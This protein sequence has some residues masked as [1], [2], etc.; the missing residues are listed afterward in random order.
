MPYEIVVDEKTGERR[1]VVTGAVYKPKAGEQPKGAG[2]TLPSPMDLYEATR[3]L[4]PQGMLESGVKMGAQVVGRGVQELQRTGDLGKAVT[5]AG[6]E[7]GR[8]MQA[9]SMIGARVGY[10]AARDLAQSVLG[11]LPAA[12]SRKPGQ[13]DSPILGVMPPLPRIKSTGAGEDLVTGFMQGAMAWILAARGG[14]L[15]AKG[16]TAIPGVGTAA[17]ATRTAAAFAQ[18]GGAVPRLAIGATKAVVKGAPTGLVVD[19]LA[20]TPGEQTMVGQILD[21]AEKQSGTPL[22]GPLVDLFRTKPGDT[23][24]D[25]RWKEGVGGLAVVGPGAE[26]VIRTTGLAA[27]AL[28]NLAKVRQAAAAS[29]AP[30]PAP[31]PTPTPAAPTPAPTAAA[32]AAVPTPA[33]AT[34]PAAPTAVV[35]A[36]VAVAAPQRQAKIDVAQQ[37][38]DAAKAK[39]DAIGPEPS[40]P[41]S[42]KKRFGA[43]G[44]AGA[45]PADVAQWKAETSTY[46]SWRRQYLK[47]KREEVAAANQLVAAK[48]ESQAPV[49]PT[50]AQTEVEEAAAQAV[51][52]VA[53]M[54]AA[55]QAAVERGQQV[56]QQVTTPPVAP[57][58]PAVGTPA[59]PSAGPPVATAPAGGLD[60]ADIA[61]LRD[62][63]GL[64][65]EEAALFREAADLLESMD[66]TTTKGIQDAR[67][68]LDRV[69][70]SER[71]FLLEGAAPT[72]R[73]AAIERLNKALEMP[74]VE[75][76][77]AP[78]AAPAPQPQAAAQA[79]AAPIDIPPGASRKITERTNENRIQVAAE[80]LASWLA[81]ING[82]KPLP[83]DRALDLVRAKGAILD[84]DAIPNLDMEA[85]RSD[86]T[87]WKAVSNTA[88]IDPVANAYKQ[89]Y[90]ARTSGAKSFDGLESPTLAPEQPPAPAAVPAAQ[91]QAA[92]TATAVAPGQAGLPDTRGQGQFFH[93]AAQEFK[94]TEGG[95]YAGDG[96]NIYGNGFYATED[97][98]TAAAYQKKNIK[99][100]PVVTMYAASNELSGAGATPAEINWLEGRGR[101]NAPA[102]TQE[103]MQEIA[104]NLRKE[105]SQ[106]P[107]N[108]ITQ[109]QLK[110]AE[111]LEDYKPVDL[112]AQKVVYQITENQ[113]IKFF[114]LDAPISAEMRDRISAIPGYGAARELV[115]SSLDEVPANASLAQVMDEIRGASKS[116]EV[117]AYDVQEIFDALIDSLKAEGYGG[118]SHEGGR[119]AGGGK[120]LHTVRIYWDPATSIS[121]EKV[122][123]G[124]KSPTLASEQLGGLDPDAVRKAGEILP[125]ELPESYRVD[126]DVAAAVKDSMVNAVRRIAGDDV[127][128]RFQEGMVFRPGTA[129]H[130]T[131]GKMRRIGGG[132]TLDVESSIQGDPIREVIDFHEMSLL[133]FKGAKVV[134]YEKLKLNVA[135]HEAFHVLQLRSMTADQ[136]KVMDTM[137]A[138]LKLYFAA[139][140]QM[141]RRSGRKDKPIELGAQAFESYDEADRAGVTPAAVMLGV[142]PDDIKFFDGLEKDDVLTKVVGTAGKAILD[143]IALVDDMFDY[144]E[145]LYNAFRGRGWTSVRDIFAQASAGQLKKQTDELGN[146]LDVIGIGEGQE[147]EWAARIRELDKQGAPAM[148]GL[149]EVAKDEGLL[150]EQ[151]PQLTSEMPGAPRPADLPPGP[152]DPDWVTSFARLLQD[153]RDRLLSGEIT[154]EDLYKLNS[155]QKAESP[156]G[157]QV[158]TAQSEDLI[159]GLNAMSQVLPDRA[160]QSGIPS[161][162]AAETVRLNQQWFDRRGEDGAAILR[163]LDAITQGFSAY[164]HGALNRAMAL[165]DLKQVEAQMEAAKWLNSVGEPGANASERLAKLM[166]AAD[167]ARR[168]HLAIMK[169]T[170]PWGQLGAEMQLPRNYD[171]PTATGVVDE[172]MAAPAAGVVEEPAVPPAPGA[173]AEAVAP[174]APGVS[175]VDQGIK[176]EL[177]QSDTVYDGLTSKVSPEL[178]E[179][180]QGGEITPKAEAD[181]D[182][183]AQAIVSMGAEPKIRTKTWRKLDEVNQMDA[184]ALL[185]LRTNNLISSGVTMM[186]NLT[187]G[188]VNLGRLGMAQTS[189]AVLS[190]DFDRAMYSIQMLGSYLSNLQNGFRVAGHA[191]KAGQPLFNMEASS[192]DYLERLAKRDAQGDLLQDDPNAMTGWTLNTMNMSQAWAETRPGQAL[193][194]LWKVVGT[195]ASRVAVSIDAFNSTVAGYSY[196]H[197]RH[198]PRGMELAVERGLK[199]HSAEAW[200]YAQQYAAARTDQAIKDAVINGKTLADVAMESPHA[201]K[202]MDAVNFTD[203]IWAELEPRTLDEGMRIGATRDLKGDELMDFAKK[204]V[205]EG[206]FMHKLA[207]GML[208]GPVPLGRIGSLPGEA[209]QTLSSARM[210][211][212]VFKFIQP[213]QRVPSNIIKS[214][215]RSTPAAVFVDSF[216]RDI[217]SSD[218]GTRQRAVG[219]IAVGSGVMTMLTLATTMGHLRING[220]GPQ[221][222]LAREKW[223]R[224]RQM[225]YSI[226]FWDQ[227]NARWNA[228]VSLA[229]ME[230]FAT[231]FGAVGDYTDVAASLPTESR[232][233]LGSALVLSLVRMQTSGILNKTYFQGINELYEAAFDPAKTFVG[234][235][236]RDPFARYLQRITASMVPYSSALRAARRQ[237]DPIARSVDPSEAGGLWGFW[238]ETWDEIRNA[239]PG[240]SQ[241]L[242]ARRDWTLPG[243]PPMVLP[244]VIGTGMI[245]EDAPFLA[246][247]MQFVPWSAFREGRPIDDPVQREMAEIHGKG[248]TFSGPRASDFGPEMRLTP[249]QLAQ[250]Q[251]VFAS[252]KDEFGRTWHQAVTELITSADYQALPIEPPSTQQVSYRA[253]FIQQ[254][255]QKY[256]ELAKQVFG[257]AT[258][259]GAEIERNKVMQQGRRDEMNFLRRYGGATTS[260]PAGAQPWS[261]TPNR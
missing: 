44:I 3:G 78:A 89:F 115:D 97:L 164:E 256:K 74:A 107:A 114:D 63:T 177:E 261:I 180:A 5:A 162:T 139:K 215:M 12:G 92:P 112:N 171:I 79:P 23:E 178:T 87:K 191:F 85:A 125:D 108:N 196:E 140:N 111:T 186:T 166:T 230:P 245:D 19:A 257:S 199:K 172:G 124:A 82:G 8:Q 37:Q 1:A 93:G 13:A 161:F 38:Y 210:I 116:F 10:N 168:M 77:P 18:G 187:N 127:V 237:V 110:L 54:E 46:N 189:G 104:A 212:P 201:Q 142:T 22:H 80:S 192:L 159:P 248:S 203:K 128:V 154:M 227:D 252:V 242:P 121:L 182:A 122:D 11:N 150:S 113:P 41:S 160:T 68:V 55:M 67:N 176:Q 184:N 98:Q 260:E 185:M 169:V 163:G 250:Y 81:P 109:R 126:P 147:K 233:R 198:M 235:A 52:A 211:G 249:S 217:T 239:V 33:A 137:F 72:P 208:N 102:L 16:L 149:L 99:A 229:A 129:A 90:G 254:E 181:A 209:L 106:Y 158:Y 39:L 157:E 76:P 48:Q 21:W 25:A 226:Q 141:G 34:A 190:G 58:V 31:A 9:P 28:F 123:L 65:P 57:E 174:P 222:P 148:K 64:S 214:A 236:Q 47:L 94:L 24:A 70:A 59:V 101:R 183:I 134:D 7:V 42:E 133:P 120:R 173:A 232:N 255:I 30:T 243:A 251:E 86:M 231:L 138:K 69:A 51:K 259:K 195:G 14:S 43:N 50:A 103:R 207:D 219:E 204:Y 194:M 132:Y 224:D 238:Q 247:M 83:L 26:A 155:F 205:D 20:F 244:Q 84:P 220:A 62:T 144:A 145:K 152:E 197:F 240:Y 71:Q 2:P 53:D 96:M 32:P 200:D 95:E 165:A 213:F 29:P 234:A 119:L 75:R 61:S 206:F 49:A 179:A 228:P 136:L 131:Q 118:F 246:A 130:G 88:A 56:A 66:A 202:F 117:P 153:N 4:G 188:I 221:D 167:S 225:P 17:Q 241:G 100:K 45:K 143:G 105:A 193:N 218:A 35:P 6:S 175:V 146:V 27:R 73:D 36:P 253:A 91:P 223:M 170:R 216:W 40:K 135:A 151:L 258:A 156:S 15:A 60:P